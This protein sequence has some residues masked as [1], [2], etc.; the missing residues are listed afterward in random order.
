MFDMRLE[1]IQSPIAATDG[2]VSKAVYS[3]HGFFI[4][5]E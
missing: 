1:T 3:L 4:I 5:N 2:K